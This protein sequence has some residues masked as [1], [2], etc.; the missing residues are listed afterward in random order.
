MADPLSITSGVLTLVV[1]ALKSSKLLYETVRSFQSNSR[2][3]RELKEELES[4]GI[5]LESL[6]ESLKNPDID[7]HALERPLTRC[8]KACH[9]FQELI[10]TNTKRSG[11]PKSS[12]RDWAKLKYLGED[13]VGF[14]NMLAAYK[15]TITIALGDINMYVIGFEIQVPIADNRLPDVHLLSLSAF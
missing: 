12:F 13:I 11:G 10:E 3:V 14:K 7:L 4:L 5:V 15:S 1:V 8:S 6:Q 2:S 9:D